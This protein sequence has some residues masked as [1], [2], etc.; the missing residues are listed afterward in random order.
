MRRE[1]R[2]DTHADMKRIIARMY[3]LYGYERAE[4]AER[5]DVGY[6]MVKKVIR[7][8]DPDTVC[9]PRRNRSN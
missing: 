7:D 6:D 8:T 1:R 2:T 9:P 5:V 4:I 3:W